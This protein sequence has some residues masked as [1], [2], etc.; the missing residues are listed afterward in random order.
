MLKL[1]DAASIARSRW[2]RFVV[3]G[4]SLRW[5]SSRRAARCPI[6]ATSLSEEDAIAVSPVGIA[7]AE[8]AL[9]HALESRRAKPERRARRGVIPEEELREVVGT[10]ARLG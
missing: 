1:S 5:A 4:R 10:I 6:C 2:L 9:V 8:C 3:V 7:H